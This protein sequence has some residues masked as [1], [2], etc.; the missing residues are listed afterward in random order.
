[1]VLLAWYWMLKHVTSP[2]SHDVGNSL[3]AYLWTESALW[4]KLYG[5]LLNSV[6]KKSWQVTTKYVT[7]RDE[8]DE[9]LPSFDSHFIIIFIFIFR[10]YKIRYDGN[11][12]FTH[13]SLGSCLV[14]VTIQT[15]L[16]LIKAG[17]LEAIFG[18]NTKHYDIIF[19]KHH[20]YDTYSFEILT[21]RLCYQ[22]Q[23]Y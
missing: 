10:A 9:R 14:K 19:R 13:A 18:R 22:Y 4:W 1:M 21:I 12:L 23:T 16:T 6:P 20:A 3:L 11:E 8:W 7:R 5:T 17:S 15:D 2:G